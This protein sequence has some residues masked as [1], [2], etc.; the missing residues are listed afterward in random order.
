MK[1]ARPLL[2]VEIFI[3]LSERKKLPRKIVKVKISQATA[4][5]VDKYSLADKLHSAY[6]IYLS[7][8]L[9]YG[10]TEQAILRYCKENYLRGE[11]YGGTAD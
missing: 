6:Q 4:K 7:A 9:K 10:V 3:P 1:K 8:I 11:S 5:L 2:T